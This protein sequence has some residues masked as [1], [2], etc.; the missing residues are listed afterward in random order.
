MRGSIARLIESELPREEG[1]EKGKGG[2]IHAS[3]M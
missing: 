3:Y 2:E 1:G